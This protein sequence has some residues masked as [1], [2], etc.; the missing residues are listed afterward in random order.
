MIVG[1]FDAIVKSESGKAANGG[2]LFRANRAES[3]SRYDAI[4][5][6]ESI[7]SWSIPGAD[8][9]PIL[10][11]TH[12]PT[13][14]PRGVILIAHGFKGYKDYG[15]FPAI[16]HHFALAGFIAHRFNFSHAGMTNDIETFARP[17]LFEADTWNKQVFDLEQVFAAAANGSLGG[18]SLSSPRGRGAGGEGSRSLPILVLGHSRGGMTALLWAGRRAE[19]PG[20]Q[21]A[22]IIPVAAP[23]RPFMFSP[24]DQKLMLAQGY[25]ESPSSRTGQTLRVGK[26]YLEEQLADPAGHDVLAQTARIRCPICIIHGETD[27]SV[28]VS[29]AHEIK[30]AAGA[31]AELVVI[32][33]ADHVFNTPNPFPMDGEPSAQLAAMLDAAIGFAKRVS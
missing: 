22:G 14:S 4:I 1:T 17:D 9:E 13:E 11:D 28:P 33:G 16:A 26:A 20:V 7:T 12:A 30:A 19:L 2:V 24:N 5:M 31:K 25:L 10:G 15:M 23:S 8:G 21:P 29:N 27:P 3:A 18:A 6:H 32:P